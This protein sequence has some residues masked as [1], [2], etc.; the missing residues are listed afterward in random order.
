[1]SPDE[2]KNSILDK[3]LGNT[4]DFTKEEKILLLEDDL[5]L[6][7]LLN[8]LYD[9]DYAQNVWTIANYQFVH[10]IVQDKIENPS[11]DENGSFEF[12]DVLIVGSFIMH[13]VK[14]YPVRQL[15]ILDMLEG[16]AASQAGSKLS[17]FPEEIKTILGKKN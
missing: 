9:D 15:E 8:S 16:A 1:M 14:K 7:S 13:L 11:V 17:E 5:L 12:R 6:M 10:S 3:C 2:L 4:V